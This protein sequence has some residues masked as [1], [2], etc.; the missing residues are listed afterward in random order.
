MVRALICGLALLAPGAAAVGDGAAL[1]QQ[2][3]HA[4]AEQASGHRAVTGL[5]QGRVEAVLKGA[6]AKQAPKTV[7]DLLEHHVNCTQWPKMCGEPFHCENYNA[8]EMNSYIFTGMAGATP[9]ANIR[10]WC[11]SPIYQEYAHTCLVEK[12]LL[13]AAH[14]Q[15]QWS[16]DAEAGI[17]ELDGSYCFIEGHCTNTAVTNQTTL[18]ESYKMCDDRF[19]K[20]WRRVGDLPSGAM[21]EVRKLLPNAQS[22]KTG[23]HNTAITKFYLK[24]ACA[25]GNYHCDVVYCK[26]TYCKKDYYV[27]KYGHLQPKAPGHLIQEREW[28]A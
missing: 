7:G 25:M 18:E 22:S 1:V 13:K 3:V 4:H 21:Q 6:S 16:L 23:F 28:L 26:E 20:S 17:D 19:G 2:G 14:F 8:L 27:K 5:L 15:Y 9:G 11:I 10:T 12:D 24:A